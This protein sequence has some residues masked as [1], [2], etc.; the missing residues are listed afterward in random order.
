MTKTETVGD[1]PHG[2]ADEM[3][4]RIGSGNKYEDGTSLGEKRTINCTR[5]IG[6]S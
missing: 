4:T 5:A 2:V 3:K 1:L 6:F